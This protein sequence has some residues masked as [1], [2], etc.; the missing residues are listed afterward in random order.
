M[1]L[2]DS[3]R[4]PYTEQIS[5]ITSHGESFYTKVKL[6]FV[7]FAIQNA[8]ESLKKCQKNST[9]FSYVISK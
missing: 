5:K 9:K 7:P 2:L 3:D 6:S 4:E 8:T 1:R